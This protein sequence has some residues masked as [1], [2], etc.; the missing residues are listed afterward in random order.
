MGRFV[1]INPEVSKPPKQPAPT[2]VKGRKGTI[3]LETTVTALSTKSA[4]STA[5]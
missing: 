4:H 1:R 5:N 3:H 2:K